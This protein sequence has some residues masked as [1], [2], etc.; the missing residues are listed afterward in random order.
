M[1]LGSSRL[2]SATGSARYCSRVRTRPPCA[3]TFVFEDPLARKLTQWSCVRTPAATTQFFHTWSVRRLF[4]GSVYQ[5]QVL[6]GSRV[7]LSS[8]QLLVTVL[9]LTLKGYGL[10]TPEWL[11]GIFFVP[12]NTDVNE[13]QWAITQQ[14]W[15][16]LCQ[17]ILWVLG[18]GSYMCNSLVINT[19]P[20][21][22]VLFA[23]PHDIEH[24]ALWV[25]VCHAEVCRTGFYSPS[26]QVERGYA[27][28]FPP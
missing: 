8:T 15:V 17:Y 28:H 10:G 1:A 27:R 26:C 23:Q 3:S 11:F 13:H 14:L 2:Y 22:L 4:P 18:I 24:E 21:A 6:Q 16:S 20:C 12:P 5:P 9:C 7:W 25:S 19:T